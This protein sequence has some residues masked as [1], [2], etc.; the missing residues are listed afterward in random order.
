MIVKNCID[1]KNYEIALYKFN[2]AL[3][4]HNGTKYWG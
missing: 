2:K 3:V 1:D 4:K